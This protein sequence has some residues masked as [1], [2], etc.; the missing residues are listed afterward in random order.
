VN[1]FGRT[2]PPEQDAVLRMVRAFPETAEAMRELGIQ[3]VVVH[4]A[5]LDD[6][7][8]ALLAAALASNECRLVAQRGSDYLFELVVP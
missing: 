1:G 8:D 2:Q 6:G 3:Y 5:R 4:T 7:A